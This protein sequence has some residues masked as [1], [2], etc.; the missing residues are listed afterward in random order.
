MSDIVGQNEP[1]VIVSCNNCKHYDFENM[2]HF[3][4][5]AFS[6]IPKEI[7]TGKNKHLSP[8]DGQ[9]NDIVFEV[10]K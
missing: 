9:V 4:C 8:L 2:D 10:L 5:K 6:N 3:A 1:L 7:L